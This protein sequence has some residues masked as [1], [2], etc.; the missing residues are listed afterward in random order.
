MIAKHCDDGDRNGIQ[1]VF[2]ACVLIFMPVVRDVAHQNQ[3]FSIRVGIQR[4][5]ARLFK[6]DEGVEIND[7]VIGIANV[8][9]GHQKYFLHGAPEAFLSELNQVPSIPERVFEDSDGA[10]GFV[11]WR[12]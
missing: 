3:H 9:V 2:Q 1:C 11:S 5:V 6:P 4:F 10:I 7:R 8:D 12:L